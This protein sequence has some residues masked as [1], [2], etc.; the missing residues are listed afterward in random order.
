MTLLSIQGW[1]YTGAESMT[2]TSYNSSATNWFEH[3]HFGLHTIL[4]PCV[5]G[6]FSNTT[7]DCP[8]SHRL[9]NRDTIHIKGNMPVTTGVST[10]LCSACPPT[11]TRLVT[12]IVVNSINGIFNRRSLAHIANKIG[13]TIFSTPSFTY[14]NASSAITFISIVVR[15]NTPR[16][17]TKPYMIDIFFRTPMRYPRKL[18]VNF[19]ITTTRFNRLSSYFATNYISQLSTIT[20]AQP[21]APMFTLS[22]IRNRGEKVKFYARYITKIICNHVLIIAQIIQDG[23]AFYQG[24]E[25]NA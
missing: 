25:Y 13:K 1:L 9:L 8:F 19:F 5:K 14:L 12:H 10:L 6:R 18:V 22:L 11:I 7:N 17:Y 3:C 23:R 2:L 20:P 16:L 24:R 21:I 15:V 4:K